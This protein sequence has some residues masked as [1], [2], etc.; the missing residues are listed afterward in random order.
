MQNATGIGQIVDKLNLYGLQA[1]STASVRPNGLKTSQKIAKVNG[2]ELLIEA[3]ADIGATTPYDKSFSIRVKNGND[4]VGYY[5][6]VNTG[7]RTS[8]SDVQ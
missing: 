5:E 1:G 3:H 7:E 2:N 6:N 4:W 8:F